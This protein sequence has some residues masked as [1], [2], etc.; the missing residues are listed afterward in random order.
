MFSGH[1]RDEAIEL[2]VAHLY[3]DPSP[4]LPPNSHLVGFLR[5]LHLLSTFKW[6]DQPLIVDIDNELS[7][8]DRESILKTFERLRAREKVAYPPLPLIPR[9]SQ[10]H[11][12]SE[13]F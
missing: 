3:T 8:N 13:S 5:F 9:T 7:S 10:H 2:M 4:F 12:I 1:V 11:N 6:Q